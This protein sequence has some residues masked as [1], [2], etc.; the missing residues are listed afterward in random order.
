[1]VEE[2]I[3]VCPSDKIQVDSCQFDVDEGCAI[4]FDDCTYQ[5]VIYCMSPSDQAHESTHQEQEIVPSHIHESTYNTMTHE[6]IL[7]QLIS[8]DDVS[9]VA[10]DFIQ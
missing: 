8:S 4:I 7:N 2:C 1:M 10:R 6:H 9:I 3:P 5:S